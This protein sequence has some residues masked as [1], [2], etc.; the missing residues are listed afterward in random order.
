MIKKILLLSYLLFQLQ[1]TAQIDTDFWFA[2]PEVSASEGDSPIVLRFLTYNNPVNN[3]TVSLPANGGFTPINIT[4]GAN[5]TGSIDLTPFIASIESPAANVVSN[6][7]IR[8]VSDQNISAYYELNNASNKEIFTL[9][10]S[11]ALGDNF[12]TPFQTFWDNSATTPASF[13][14]IDIVA[15]ENNTTVLITPRTNIT[16]NAQDVTFS[17]VLNQ[18]ETY[19]ARDMNVTGASTLAGSIVSSDKPIALTLF[20]GSLSNSTCSNAMGDQIT[21]EVYTGSKYIVHKSTSGNDRVYILATQNGTSITIDNS[22][23]TTTLINWGETYEVALSD[24]INYI[25]ASKPVYV[26][27][28]SGYG[29]ELSGAQVP[30][31]FCAGTYSTAFTRTSTDSLGLLLYTRTGFENQF[32]LNG[33]P[34]LIPA[35]AFSPVPGTA[36]TFQVALI[37]YSTADVPVNSY[38]EVTNSGDIFGLGVM[39]GNSGSGASYG[40]LSEFASYP[41][42]SGGADAS[43]CANTSLNLT[44]LVGGGSVTGVWSGTGFGSF[45]NPTDQLINTYLPS[46]LDTIISPIELILT[47]TGPCPVV[48]DTITITVEPAPIVTASADQSLCENNSNVQ[49]AGDVTGGATTGVWAST[50]T[51]VF[52]PNNTTFN[53]IYTPSAADLTAGS[54]QLVLTS[55]NFGSCLTE[56]DTME[57][58]FSPPPIVDSGADTLYS[59]ENN[60]LVN[61]SGTVSGATTTGKWLSSGTGV[62]SPDN[63]SL[64]ASYQPSPGDILLG[65]VLL[66][67]ES[68]SNL[69]CIPVLDSV[70]IIFTPEPTVNAGTNFLTC[71]NNATIT[72]NG[73][74]A[75]ATTTGVWTGGAGV[76]SP[77][78]TDL[79]A[80]YTPTAGEITSGNVFLTLTTTNN[81]T[82][83]SVNDNVQISFIAPPTANFNFTEVCLNNQ[84]VFTDFSLSGFGN[85]SN[86]TWDFNDGTN[87][88]NQDENHVYTTPGA[89]N[90]QLLVTTNAGCSD[91]I[92]Q[93][94]NV[95]E[96]P[97]ADF[98]FSSNCPNNQIIV[99]FVDQSTTVSDPINFWY[100][101]FGGQGTTSTEDPTQ[102]FSANGNY[103]ILHIVGT[104]NGCFDTTSQ[105]LTVSPLPVANFSYNLNTSSNVTAD[106]NF[107]N[108]S[109]DAVT[110]TW[111]F[112]N[113]ISSS[114]INPSITYFTNNNYIITLYATSALGCVD[115]TSQ[116]I[117]I[118]NIVPPEEINTLIPNAI[119]PN[120]DGKNDV[121]KLDFLNVLYPNAIVQVYNGWGQ[122]LFESEGY[123]VPWDGTY[124]GENVPDGN[125][126]YII[127]IGGTGQESEIFKGVILVLKSKN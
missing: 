37:H 41:F 62:F 32:A 4:L 26:W 54:V 43:I 126:F 112:G 90:V 76:Y 20:S 81:G 99:D 47:T 91:S 45:A 3:I 107:V 56:S 24:A 15:T 44:G 116:I 71:T 77:N 35:G 27:H 33:S 8:I 122:Q 100:Y 48:R 38:N 19:S 25:N 39:N 10:G 63:L 127:D 50:G 79:N 103:T 69:S 84:S 12:Y 58:V 67:L 40:Y 120:G 119:S 21:S 59:C 106:V 52:S 16:G 94:V 80:T 97:V 61:L 73:A 83:L 87:S 104:A 6:N 46:P 22:G 108:S 51:G 125:Y 1:L 5:Q 53:A 31:V 9:K 93:L 64:S 110:Y 49:L 7:G 42:V 60:S 14:S 2:A 29:C 101:D 85:I 92:T 113:G 121:W 118:D 11:K 86:W 74:V 82:C 68:T 124:N 34:L 70:L 30:P 65:S 57:V 36:G 117:F 114:D 55:T 96:V 75:G 105:L 95:W 18:G 88:N 109:T 98:S 17:V 23:T 123:A 89:Y 78:D 66:H 13:S 102:L 111:N 72:L 28:A 115:S